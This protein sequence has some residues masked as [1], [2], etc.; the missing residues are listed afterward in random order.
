VFKKR[1]IIVD[2]L[3][4]NNSI[5]IT[6]STGSGKSTQICQ[7]LIEE[8]VHCKKTIAIVQ[9]RRMAAITLA[10]RVAIEQQTVLGKKVGYHVRF[11]NTTNKETCIKFLTNGMLIRESMGKE[12]LR[13]YSI[14]VLDEAHESEIPWN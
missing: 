4:K 5:I 3:I 1:N 14:I 10:E 2:A 8:R 7:Y 9:P 13:N 12:R 11:D 6:G